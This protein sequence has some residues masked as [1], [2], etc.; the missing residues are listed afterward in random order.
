MRSCKRS[1]DPSPV[2]PPQRPHLRQSRFAASRKQVPP[3]EA[4]SR[5]GSPARSEAPAPVPRP[6]AAAAPP[7][8]KPLCGEPKAP[9]WFPPPA[10]RSRI[11]FPG[12]MRGGKNTSHGATCEEGPA[13]W[14]GPSSRQSGVHGPSGIAGGAVCHR[15]VLWTARGRGQ[16]EGGRSPLSKGITR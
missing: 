8:A 9:S 14:A 13:L 7:P 1:A 10:E 6:A 16:V 15:A 4:G 3:I 2:L 12:D 11:I 5:P